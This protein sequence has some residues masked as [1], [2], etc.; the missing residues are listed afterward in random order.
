MCTGLY[1]GSYLI[2]LGLLGPSAIAEVFKEGEHRLLPPL[3]TRARSPLQPLEML[4]IGM[5][6]DRFLLYAELQNWR[7]FQTETV[8]IGDTWQR[9][10]ELL[11]G[12]EAVYTPN[13]ERVYARGFIV[14]AYFEGDRLTGL[15]FRRNPDVPAFN[16]TQLH[17]LIRAWFPDNQVVL[18]Y[19]F[20]PE[21]SSR[22][23]IGAYVG[24]IPVAFL[25]DLLDSDFLDTENIPLCS[26]VLVPR[27]P[28]PQP[29]PSINP[30]SHCSTGLGGQETAER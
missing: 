27:V 28:Q 19:Q 22:Q 23:V 24:D 17:R 14:R 13:A 8:E 25:S 7:S 16:I 3:Q 10:W 6:L 20:L 21:D 5:R 18:H 12:G 26:S 29:L 11:P 2:G 30:P 4:Y 9:W 1:L 15:Q